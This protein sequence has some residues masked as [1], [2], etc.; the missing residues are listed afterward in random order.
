MVVEWLILSFY[1]RGPARDKHGFA[2]ALPG[3]GKG[4]GHAG[5]RMRVVEGRG[6]DGEV[7]EEQDGGKGTQVT[8]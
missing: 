8:G 6:E 4:S 2:Q 5:R 1:V 3:V 7:V